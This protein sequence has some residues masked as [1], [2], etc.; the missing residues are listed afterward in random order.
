MLSEQVDL[1]T[2]SQKVSSEVT[3]RV[4]ELIMKPIRRYHKVL[5]DDIQAKIYNDLHRPIAQFIVVVKKTFRYLT[6]FF[7]NRTRVYAA[8]PYFETL[9]WKAA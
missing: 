8:L 6:V 2:L 9:L 7:Y 1:K 3:C 4:D 5:P